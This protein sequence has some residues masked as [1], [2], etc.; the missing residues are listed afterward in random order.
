[1][2]YSNYTWVS[3]A[4]LG[5]EGPSPKAEGNSE[6]LCFRSSL[7]MA[8]GDRRVGSGAVRNDLDPG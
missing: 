2:L 4:S 5:K 7:D 8:P 3:T 1:M 6:V